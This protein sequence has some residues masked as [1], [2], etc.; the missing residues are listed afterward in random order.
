MQDEKEICLHAYFLIA[1]ANR[2][3]VAVD[4]SQVFDLDSSK[5]IGVQQITC[6][7]RIKSIYLSIF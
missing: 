1:S 3:S 2:T 5:G 7:G 6:T 4:D